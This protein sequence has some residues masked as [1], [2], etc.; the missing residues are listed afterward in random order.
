MIDLKR[1]LELKGLSSFDDLVKYCG[2]ECFDQLDRMVEN[3]EVSVHTESMGEKKYRYPYYAVKVVGQR[4]SKSIKV[5]KLIE[6]NPGMNATSIK[7][8]LK[9]SQSSFERWEKELLEGGQITRVKKGAAWLYYSAEAEVKVPTKVPM[10][11]WYVFFEHMQLDF[12]PLSLQQLAKNHRCSREVITEGQRWLT[13]QGILVGDILEG[14]WAK[15]VEERKAWLLE[16]FPN[17]PEYFGSWDDWKIEDWTVAKAVVQTKPLAQPD[18]L[19]Q[20]ILEILGKGKMTTA[21]I[22]QSVPGAETPG[23]LREE[24]RLKVLSMMD[25]GLLNRD[26]WPRVEDNPALFSRKIRV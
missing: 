12:K 16:T 5:L 26:W 6:D 18:E 20:L 22:A 25:S 19:G 3:R 10:G 2:E 24:V 4:P 11:A 23:P 17:P 9:V 1:F 8:T 14:Y 7:K 21:E 15:S 13:E